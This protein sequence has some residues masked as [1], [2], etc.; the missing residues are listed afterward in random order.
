MTYWGQG[1][2]R[3][4]GGW[5]FAL[6]RRLQGG[7]RGRGRGSSWQQ[8]LGWEPETRLGK[9]AKEG[10]LRQLEQAFLLSLPIREWEILAYSD[11][12]LGSEVLFIETLYHKA[13]AA[14]GRNFL[15]KT[16]V[17]CAV[18]VGDRNGHVGVAVHTARDRK[19]A[20]VECSKKAGCS[21]MP[22]R[23]GYYFKSR[24][25]EPTTVAYKVS[26]ESG[27]VVV[28]LY[29]AP[30]GTGVVCASA[31]ARTILELAGI[32]DVTTK[33]SSGK[34]SPHNVVMATV[35]ALANLSSRARGHWDWKYDGQRD[36]QTLELLMPGAKP[37]HNSH[38][39]TCPEE[40]AAIGISIEQ[41][42]ANSNS[43]SCSN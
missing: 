29:P 5:S 21:I 19:S 25:G 23:R 30:K 36:K 13:K 15:D 2:G 8:S 12:T 16:S 7:G 4:R 14:R 32:A 1:G 11:L 18:A 24:S 40:E 6:Q 10:N 35:D 42:D 17:R 39:N 38:N 27:G 41:T 26:G 22:I 9:V 20:L 3:G 33:V 28:H 43:N 37:N 31:P 34:H